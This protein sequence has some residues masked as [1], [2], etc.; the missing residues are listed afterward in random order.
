VNKIGEAGSSCATAAVAAKARNPANSL[1]LKDVYICSPFV[2]M[3]A[4][5][6]VLEA[7]RRVAALGMS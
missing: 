4:L 7:R 2:F 5:N 3:I 6:S 1:L